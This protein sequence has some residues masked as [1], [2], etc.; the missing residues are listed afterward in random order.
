MHAHLHIG[1]IAERGAAGHVALVG[2]GLRGH[3]GVIADGLEHRTAKGIGAVVLVGGFLDGDAAVEY[4]LIA[5]IALLGVVG[6]HGMC[7]VAAYKHRGGKCA[8]V[9]LVVKAQRSVNAAQRVGQ[10]RRHGA[11][12]GLGANLLVI[13]AA[14]DRD[15][16]RVLG[17]QKCLQRGVGAGQ[18]IELGRRDKLVSPAPNARILTIDQEQVAAQ[19]LLGLNIQLVGD[20]GIKIALLKFAGA[21][22][23][24]QVDGSVGS[25]ALVNAAVHVDGKARDNSDLALGGKQAALNTVALAHQHATRERQRAI[26]PGVVDHAAVCLGVQAQ[27]LACAAELGHGLDLKRRRIAVRRRELKMIVTGNAV[28]APRRGQVLAH[29][30]GNNARGVALRVITPARLD[31]PRRVLGQVGKARFVELGHNGRRRMEHAGACLDKVDKVVGGLDIIGR[32][33]RAL[34]RFLI[35]HALPFRWVDGPLQHTP[36]RQRCTLHSVFN[37]APLTKLSHHARAPFATI[38]LTGREEPS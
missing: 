5:G 11:L 22:E 29:L 10:E 1:Q 17:T 23:R 27:R 9:R 37:S 8:M 28:L 2:E 21:D 16:V 35:R 20:Q 32:H 7:I 36:P 15:V 4:N 31:V 38:A 34:G 26:E 3:V 30:K 12:L 18:V 13:E 19:D 6:V 24:A 14:E 33:M 25:K